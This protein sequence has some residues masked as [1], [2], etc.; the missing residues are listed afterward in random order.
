[1]FKK[2]L[3]SGLAVGALALGAPVAHADDP[4]F[5][6]GFNSVQQADATGQNYEGAVYGYVIDTDA[7]SVSI[8]CYVKV[9]GTAVPPGV[10]G[11][12]TVAAHAEGRITFTAQDTDDVQLCGDATV[13]HGSTTATFTHCDESTH[14]Q[15]PPQEVIDILDALF[16]GTIDPLLCPILQG[17]AGDYAGVITIGA[18][19]DLTVAGELIEDC[20]PYQPIV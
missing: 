11:S 19:G 9:N 12:G 2:I 5:D 17:L 15:V 1:L 10:S 20:P 3:I 14:T 6:C 16:I 4:T 8:H 18:D 13:T 7:T